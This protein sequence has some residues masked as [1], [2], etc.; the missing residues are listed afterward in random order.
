[1]FDLANCFVLQTSGLSVVTKCTFDSFVIKF[2]N[3]VLRTYI[4]QNTVFVFVPIH[5][6]ILNNQQ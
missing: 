5:I 1:M 2:Q 3:N 4:L 6:K